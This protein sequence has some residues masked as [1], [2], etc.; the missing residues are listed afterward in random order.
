MNKTI[1]YICCLFLSASAFSTIH[2][3]IDTSH[4]YKQFHIEFALDSNDVNYF[5]EMG[6]QLDSCS[7][8]PLYN[9][10]CNWLGTS[11][12]YAGNS[13]KGIDCSGLVKAVFGKIFNL[14]LSGGSSDIFPLTIPIEKE[15]LLEGDL[16][17][18]KIAKNRISHVGIYLS[19]N[20][21]IHAS[22]K[23]GVIISD[24]NE[25]YYKKYFYAAGRLP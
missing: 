25:S 19:N 3:Q 9:E 5:Y 17:F 16:V 7:Y 13:N 11:Y 15:H 20:K 10:M 1:K 4:F 24:L 8:T 14:P 12:K 6:L 22:V 21:F 2:A 18:F 23:L